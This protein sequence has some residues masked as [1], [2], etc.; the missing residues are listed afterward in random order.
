MTIHGRLLLGLA[1]L[2]VV[3]CDGP[4]VLPLLPP[5]SVHPETGL[6]TIP[7]DFSAVPSAAPAPAEHAASRSPGSGW[8]VLAR[9]RNV[10]VFGKPDEVQVRDQVVSF[11]IIAN[12]LRK[13]TSVRVLSQA[14]CGR[15]EIL[16]QREELFEGYNA[17]GPLLKAQARQSRWRRV[18][19]GSVAA[20]M[21]DF[22]CAQH[23]P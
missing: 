22:A 20:R 21:I 4:V 17:Q 2:L 12:N 19:T 8:V 5:T 6:R 9:S 10:V 23:L 1:A 16:R 11:W 3:A 15:R 18:D 13:R 14:H 7:R